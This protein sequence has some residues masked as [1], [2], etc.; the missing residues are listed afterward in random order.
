VGTPAQRPA[1]VV[2]SLV[3][4]L[5]L[6]DVNILKLLATGDEYDWLRG[7]ENRVG[8]VF[9]RLVVTAILL[10]V[11]VPLVRRRCRPA[12]ALVPPLRA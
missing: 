8:L 2:V 3:C 5:D 4:V 10:A 1:A 7:L 11:C 6:R 12:V 9:L